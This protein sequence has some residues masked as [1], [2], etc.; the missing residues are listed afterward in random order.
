M[1]PQSKLVRDF[2]NAK[3]AAAHEDIRSRL[4]RKMSEQR[5]KEISENA[6]GI[7]QKKPSPTKDFNQARGSEPEHAADKNKK[8]KGTY[9]AFRDLADEVTQGRRNGGGRSFTKKPPKGPEFR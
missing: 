6:Q 8:N 2:E 4:R 1:T 5:E 3:D 7:T 9:R